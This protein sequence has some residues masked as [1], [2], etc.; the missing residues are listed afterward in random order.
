MYG[1]FTFRNN[2]L[3]NVFPILPVNSN[4][5]I[6]EMQVGKNIEDYGQFTISKIG[7]ELNEE[8]NLKSAKDKY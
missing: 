3:G 7:F 1:A 6:V 4:C 2:R 5:M 8:K